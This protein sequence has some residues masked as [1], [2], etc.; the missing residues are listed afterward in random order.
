M[1]DKLRKRL[2]FLIGLGMSLIVALVGLTIIITYYSQSMAIIYSE[3][4][5]E[6]AKID[7]ETLAALIPENLPSTGTS[8]TEVIANDFDFGQDIAIF[9]ADYNRSNKQFKGTLRYPYV[10]CFHDSD[11]ADVST[12][13]TYALSVADGKDEKGLMGFTVFSK[14]E[15]SSGTLVLFSGDEY[16]IDNIKVV[17]STTV[18]IFVL[19]LLFSSWLGRILSGWL[20]KPIEDTLDNQSTF[21]SDVSHELKTPLAVITSNADVLESD[22]G[23][24]KWLTSIKNES[25]RMAGLISELLAASRLERA[26]DAKTFEEVDFSSIVNETVMTFDAMA[27]EK[28]VLIDTDIADNI[29]VI[30]SPEKLRRLIGILLDNAVKYAGDPGSITVKLSKGFGNVYL[31]VKNTGSYVEKENRKKIFDRFYRV[32]QSRARDENFG[33]YGLGL[34]I[35]RSIVE[36]HNGSIVCQS[37]HADPDFTIFKVTL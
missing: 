30:G 6:F 19:G 13:V 32:D 12:M 21:I 22:I 31:S 23:E 8:E 14:H 1:V 9:V 3:M 18:A 26:D 33:S 36:E 24:S 20:V 2:S 11:N 34:S 28:G 17:I 27:F 15:Y 29:N 5:S 25:L 10:L 37:A 4:A 16:F 35:A 7:D